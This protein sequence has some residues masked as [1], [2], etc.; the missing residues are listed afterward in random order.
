M[1]TFNILPFGLTETYGPRRH[2]RSRRSARKG[3][4]VGHPA[5]RQ[6]DAG[7]R[8]GDAARRRPRRGRR[9]LAARQRHAGLLEQAGRNRGHVHRGRLDAQPGPRL[10]RCRR[11]HFLRRPDQAD[12]Q[13]RRRERLDRGSRERRRKPRRRG[14][15]RRGRR[16][17]RAAGGSR[18]GLRHAAQGPHARRSG[19]A[20]LAR[21]AAR[22]LQA[23]ARHHLRRRAARTSPTARRTG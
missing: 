16:A 19:T 17:R 14:R 18:A 2:R 7:G 20:A 3:R 10:G 1:S 12:A 21:G 11:L 15:M 23:A 9:G 13:G 6:R 8:S 5:R 4:Q 22:P